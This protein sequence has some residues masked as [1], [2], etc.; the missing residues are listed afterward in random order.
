[1]GNF[2]FHLPSYLSSMFAD[3][4]MAAQKLIC[5]PSRKLLA[6]ALFSA[7]RGRHHPGS[8][9][10]PLMNSWGLALRRLRGL[11]RP[12]R[13][14]NVCQ[15]GG[16]YL[17]PSRFRPGICS[18]LAKRPLLW[19]IFFC[20]WNDSSPFRSCQHFVADTLS[21]PLVHNKA[22]HRPGPPH[23]QLPLCL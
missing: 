9:V 23:V 20:L 12:Q 16:V 13:E 14:V 10:K 2:S 7:T 19:G 3:G 11:P 17:W 18:S 4:D 22:I 21:T 5:S 8:G 15:A 6:T 1:M